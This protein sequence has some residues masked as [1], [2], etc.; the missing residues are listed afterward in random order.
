[1]LLSAQVGIFADGF[2]LTVITSIHQ[3]GFHHSLALFSYSHSRD[4]ERQVGVMSLW[5]IT[6]FSS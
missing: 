5:G 6:A 3:T 2:H 1:V 4:L